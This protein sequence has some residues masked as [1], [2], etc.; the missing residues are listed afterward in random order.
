MDNPAG[1]VPERRLL[2]I[3]HAN[4]EDNAAASWFA[5]QLTLMGYEVWCDLKN[6]HGGESDFW[7]KVQK[8]IENDAAK[9][10]FILSNA[11]RDFETKKGVYKEIQA[12]VGTRRENFV[13]P[14]RVEKLTGSV[15]ILI[16]TDI[17]INAENWATGLRELHSRLSEDGVS[18]VSVPDLARIVSWW[19]ALCAPQKLLT[20]TASEL[21]SNI[22]SVKALPAS[23][24][25][26]KIRSHGNV[27]SGYDQLHSLLPPHPAHAVHGEYAISFGRA[28][29][30]SA[31]LPDY[32]V[33]D[34]VVFAAQE[35]FDKGYDHG[36]I[37][38]QAARNIMT[39]L[40]ASGLEQLLAVRGLTQ[41]QIPRR[42]RRIWFPADGL[43][44]LN[45]YS[46]LEPQ[47][48]RRSPAWFVGSFSYRRKR[49]FWHFGVQPVVD[50]HTH[51]GILF[52][53]RVVLTLPYRSDRDERPFPI[54]HK[55]ALKHLLWWNKEWR[56][57]TLAFLAWLANDG[58][59]IRIPV[60]YQEILLSAQPEVFESELT[61]VDEDDD[62]LIKDILGWTN[63]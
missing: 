19:P 55:K 18:K 25:L 15:P 60:G 22:A 26:L 30:F 63:A 51:H 6:T 61:Y 39:Y 2:F 4:P 21:V 62:S 27:L 41:K 7:L 11:S 46:I 52:S 38:R 28:A 9:L 3:S 45:K 48:S 17:Y 13:I 10:I 23:V 5:T 8:K 36:G 49:Y 57:K 50:L 29:D 35:F 32:H 54:D 24:H 1:A 42:N 20:T 58:D 16:G 33:T 56:T 14:L 37:D 44:R 34:E 59:V 12:A 47:G 31:A 53:P 43:I 40:V